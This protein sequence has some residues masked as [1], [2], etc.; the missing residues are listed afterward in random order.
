MDNKKIIPTREMKD[1]RRRIME[2]QVEVNLAHQH[3]NENL[4]KIKKLKRQLKDAVIGFGNA[5]KIIDEEIKELDDFSDIKEWENEKQK[6]EALFFADFGKYHWDGT[7]EWQKEKPL[8][9]VKTN[10]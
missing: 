10:Q 8:P 1:R 9:K 6:A 3:K 2:L 7:I 4:S 5:V